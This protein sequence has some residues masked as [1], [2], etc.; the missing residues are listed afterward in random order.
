[1]SNQSTS[2]R[3]EAD[4]LIRTLSAAAAQIEPTSDWDRL[5]TDI[6]RGKAGSP[7]KRPSNRP[8]LLA[9]AAAVIAIGAGGIALTTISD[10]SPNQISATKPNYVLPGEIILSEDPLTVLGA[11]GPEPKFDTSELG[12]EIAFEPVEELD[13]EL[14]EFMDHSGL[15]SSPFADVHAIKIVALG[16][17][18]GQPWMV[19]IT[20]EPNTPAFGDESPDANV[21]SRLLMSPD[22][23]SGTGDIVPVDSLELI[24]SP[25]IEQNGPVMGSG[26]SAGPSMGWAHVSFMPAGTAVVSYTD[27]QQRLWMR[28]RSGAAVFPAEFED[29]ESFK[30][31]AFDA[32]GV[33]IGGWSE[34]VDLN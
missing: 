33:L 18:E 25:T 16:T 19:L 27:D 32:D 22:G 28:P 24:V 8:R 2:H 11:L 26:W 7:S 21:R 30:V 9:A 31:R 13:P 23:G 29:G 4:T 14:I 17:M 10:P 6:S 5:L 3:E 12:R 15:G 1:M 20:D 34:T